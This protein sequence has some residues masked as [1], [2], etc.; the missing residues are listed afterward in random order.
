MRL[1]LILLLL[2]SPRETEVV[3]HDI[4]SKITMKLAAMAEFRVDTRAAAEMIIDRAL[5]M[6][7]P[8]QE[9]FDN[10]KGN[11]AKRFG[12]F[13]ILLLLTRSESHEIAQKKRCSFWLPAF[14]NIIEINFL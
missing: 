6:S 5:N 14:K 12:V 4:W 13:E 7:V 2:F 3:N 11:R 8:P 1:P 9:Y 10:C